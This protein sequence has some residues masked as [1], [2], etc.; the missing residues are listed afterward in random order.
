VK[1][2][3]TLSGIAGMF[4]KDPRLWRPIA[5]RNDVENPRDLQPGQVLTIPQII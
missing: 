4:Y 1:I 5:Q 3:D 2:G